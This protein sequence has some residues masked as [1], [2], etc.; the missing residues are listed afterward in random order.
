MNSLICGRARVCIPA[1]EEFV[2]GIGVLAEDASNGTGIFSM[3]SSEKVDPVEVGRQVTGRE[4]SLHAA[5]KA[6]YTAKQM[7]I[8]QKQGEYKLEKMRS[9]EQEYR[10]DLKKLHTE[11][12]EIKDELAGLLGRK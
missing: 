3:S 5:R 12:K 1:D 4:L 8:A 9:G 10:S 7:N 11:R 2:R 6:M